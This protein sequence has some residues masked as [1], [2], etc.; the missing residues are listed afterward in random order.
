[1][2][3]ITDN[4]L[5]GTLTETKP[6]G[7]LTLQVIDDAAGFYTFNG[8]AINANKA[9]IILPEDAGVKGL[10]LDFG[11]IVTGISDVSGKVNADAKIYDLSGRRVN[12]PAKGIYVSDGKKVLIK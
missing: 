7:A 8:T 1:M 6:D 4:D 11:G 9:Y 5:Q 2:D 3:A 10:A 12:A